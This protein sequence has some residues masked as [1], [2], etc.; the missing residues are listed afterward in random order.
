VGWGSSTGTVASANAKTASGTY[1]SGAIT[2]P[3]GD[4]IFLFIVFD[5]LTATT[6]TISSITTAAS[7]TASWVQIAAGDSASSTAA[8][9]I[10]AELWAI[11]PTVTWTAFSPVV[12]LSG[13]VTAKAS[14]GFCQSGGSLTARQSLPMALTASS[15]ASPSVT[16]TGTPVAADLVIGLA[17]KQQ[18]QGTFTADSDTTNG[19]WS[20]AIDSG[21]TGGTSNT[22]VNAYIQTKI[23]TAGGN[24]TFNLTNGL[25]TGHAGVIAMVPFTAAGSATLTATATLTAGATRDQ[26]GAAA[27]T[28][29]ATLTA[30]ATREQFATA[31]L[32]AVATLTATATQ[33]QFA[34]ATLTA[35]STLS[36]DATRDQPADVS[37]ITTS[38]LVADASGATVLSATASLVATSTLTAD[39]TREQPAAVS[40]TAVST[41]TTDAIRQPEGAAALVSTSTLTAAALRTAEGAVSLTTTATLMSAALDPSNPQLR[42]EMQA[43]SPWGMWLSDEASG[44]TL[45]DS[46]P[47]AR[48]MTITGTP[49]AY[50]VQG[51]GAYVQGISWPATTTDGASTGATT[52]TMGGSGASITLEAWVYL[53][54]NPAAV[55]TLIQLDNVSNTGI[56]L[57]IQA[58]GAARFTVVSSSASFV[59]SS[60]IPLN[61]WVHVVGVDNAN[62]MSI[63]VNKVA[64][65]TNTKA[66]S[67]SSRPARIHSGTGAGAAAGTIGPTAVY[68]SALSTARIDTHYDAGIGAKATLTTTSTLSAT[69]VREAPATASLTTTSTLTADGTRTRPDTS[70]DQSWDV[71][72]RVEKTLTETWDTQVVLT[73]DS[74][75]ISQ[76]WDVDTRLDLT[77]QESWR[78]GVYVMTG[79]VDPP[80]KGTSSG[81]GYPFN[82][83]F[84]GSAR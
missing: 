30:A 17:D 23:V 62:A 78:V 14:A 69:A 45:A 61:Q 80:G 16:T 73:R 66:M 26:P 75:S 37:L 6:P 38:T 10:R 1:T 36:A 31:T 49:T 55:L 39:G 22:N 54:S 18:P 56:H 52:Y 58:S 60:A 42:V 72:A 35:T 15:S 43:D 77:L 64:G 12:T 50:R 25:S 83:R 82:A 8:A 11:T 53:T 40:F 76:S 5:N 24:Q 29:T 70:L 47:N 48:P 67:T 71:R 3:I 81:H 27:L 34:A 63:R 46:S 7:E 79:G 41:L 21:T 57:T 20:A 33:E 2:C 32:T 59:A 13:S 84:V 28:A 9:G 74:T 4:Q 51:A 19:S 65:N 68:P 44:S